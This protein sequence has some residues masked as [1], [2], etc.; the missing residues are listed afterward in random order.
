[1]FR[2]DVE[3]D[4]T[5][6][7]DAQEQRQAATEYVTSMGALISQALPAVQAAPPLGVFLGSVIKA[8]GRLYPFGRQ[9]EEELDQ[10]I[11]SIGEMPPQPNPDEQ[12]Q[13]GK[14]PEELAIEAQKV[15]LQQAELKQSGEQT[16]IEAKTAQIQSM[17]KKE[18]E[19]A[20]IASDE[21]MAQLEARV[22]QMTAMLEAQ[23]RGHEAQTDASTRAYESDN[24]YD[25]RQYEAEQA[26]RAA[27]AKPSNGGTA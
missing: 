17:D 22:A 7:A 21:R 1:M 4:S 9:F 14:T 10:A 3:A 11:K 23:T 15:Q 20:K 6:D 27:A 25:I 26:R 13:A 2:V 12:K 24:D 8:V 18:V 19:L 16:M 5:I